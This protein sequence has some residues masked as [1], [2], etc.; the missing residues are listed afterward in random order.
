MRG[1][2]QLSEYLKSKEATGFIQ[3]VYLLNDSD[4]HPRYHLSGVTEEMFV[5]VLKPEIDRLCWLEKVDYHAKD[6]L[7]P[8]MYVHAPFV[9][10]TVR[11]LDRKV[12]M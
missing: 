6:S 8:T 9:T 2:I 11:T 5:R 10:M 4:T 1:L 12:W 7:H 3:S